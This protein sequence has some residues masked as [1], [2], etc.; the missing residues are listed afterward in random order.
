MAYSKIYYTFQSPDQRV[1]TASIAMQND[2][3]SDGGSFCTLLRY[4][5]KF[6]TFTPSFTNKLPFSHQKYPRRYWRLDTSEKANHYS[7]ILD[8]L[9]LLV[10]Y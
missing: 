4:S 5:S 3:S 9:P 1:F 2:F 7:T 10:T 6:Q 8:I